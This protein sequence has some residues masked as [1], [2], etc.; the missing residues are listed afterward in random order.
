MCN[1]PSIPF[2]ETLIC[3]PVIGAVATKNMC[4]FLIHAI[5][6]WGISS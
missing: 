1:V 2:G 6:L 3:S 5:W 4:C